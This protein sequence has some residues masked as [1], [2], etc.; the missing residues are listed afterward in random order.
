MA[1]ATAKIIPAIDATAAKI[2]PTL[3]VRLFAFG[4]SFSLTMTITPRFFE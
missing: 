3:L 1:G 2:A 4:V